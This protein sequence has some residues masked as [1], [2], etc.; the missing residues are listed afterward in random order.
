[1]KENRRKIVKYSSERI[2]ELNN[3][4]NSYNKDCTDLKFSFDDGLEA[5]MRIKSRTFYDSK[6]S[7]VQTLSKRKDVFSRHERKYLKIQGR[8]VFTFSQ[9]FSKEFEDDYDVIILEDKV[10]TKTVELAK[11]TYNYIDDI[12]KMGHSDF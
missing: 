3:L 7:I 1:M 6:G 12:L 9:T 2:I 5:E 8:Y 11:A 10:H 4:L